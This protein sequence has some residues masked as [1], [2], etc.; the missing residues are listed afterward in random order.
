MKIQQ[1]KPTRREFCVVAV[2]ASMSPFLPNLP[3]NAIKPRNLTGLQDY[4]QT[5]KN[6]FNNLDTSYIG[7]RVHI[8]NSPE[9]VFKRVNIPF[10]QNASNLL[11]SAI[12]S[13]GGALYL[14]IGA[15]RLNE[16]SE[17]ENLLQNRQFKDAQEYTSK[18]IDI[19]KDFSFT[20]EEVD[21]IIDSKYPETITDE[22]CREA[23]RLL[24][25]ELEKLN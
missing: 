17:L 12:Y 25:K 22:S 14:T 15:T 6:S 1:Y 21:G 9:E 24:A 11:I 4:L 20:D 10:S 18:K 7:V 8:E 13:I 16:F 5:I 3:N 23:M 19:S 2:S